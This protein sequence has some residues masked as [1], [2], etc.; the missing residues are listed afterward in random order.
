[1]RLAVVLLATRLLQP[2]C[3]TPRANDTVGE[4]AYRARARKRARKRGKDRWTAAGSA[5]SN[6]T[7][8]GWTE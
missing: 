2:S 3:R 8:T 5:G 6:R 1:V 4:V 7:V